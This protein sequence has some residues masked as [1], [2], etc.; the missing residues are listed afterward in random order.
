MIDRIYTRDR[1]PTRIA[2]SWLN[3]IAHLVD[4]ELGWRQ[5]ALVVAIAWQQRP[6]DSILGLQLVLG[7]QVAVH[8]GVHGLSLGYLGRI[9]RLG[10]LD[11]EDH[12]AQLVDDRSLGLHEFDLNG[13]HL[14]SD[15]GHSFSDLNRLVDL[16]PKDGY[17][18]AGVTNAPFLGL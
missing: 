7:H 9:G 16:L 5:V 13:A 3:R 17:A 11:V 14:P 15:P 8:V 18:L 1:L 6:N 4:H 12:I 10:R 2:L